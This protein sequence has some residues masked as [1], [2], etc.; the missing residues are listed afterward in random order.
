MATNDSLIQ[1]GDREDTGDNE[2]RPDEM[3]SG[4]GHPTADPTSFGGT[5]SIRHP[6][7]AGFDLEEELRDT[8]GIESVEAT[9]GRLGLTNIG[10]VPADDWAADTGET[11]S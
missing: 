8:D 11:K 4:P 1:R 10:D 3:G 5:S 7:S 6:S 9:D 2:A